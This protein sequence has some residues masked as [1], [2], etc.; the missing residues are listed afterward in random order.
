[1]GGGNIGRGLPVLDFPELRRVGD[2]ATQEIRT[3]VSDNICAVTP[4]G[5]GGGIDAYAGFGGSVSG[6]YSFD[7]RT[8]QVSSFFSVGVG[9][10]ALAGGYGAL[11]FNAPTGITGDVTLNA[12]FAVPIGPTGFTAGASTGYSILGSSAG[13]PSSTLSRGGVGSPGG[14]ANLSVGGSVGT[15]SLW[16]SGCVQ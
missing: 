11:T 5:V 9:V 13:Q 4:I 15:P 6:G 7:I 14:F 3:F 1:M 12:G 16:D 2:R 10:G 8:G